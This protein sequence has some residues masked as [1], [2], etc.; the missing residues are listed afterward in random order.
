MTDETDLVHVLMEQLAIERER[1]EAALQQHRS[2]VET[3]LKKFREQEL[4]ALRVLGRRSRS[5]A[6]G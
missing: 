1:M 5:S 2:E 3:E 4:E 6:P